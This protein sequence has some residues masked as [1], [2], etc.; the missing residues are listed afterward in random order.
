MGMSIIPS[1]GLSKTQVSG[2]VVAAIIA[3]SVGIAAMG[4]LTYFRKV[5]PLKTWLVPYT[6]TSQY[7]GIFLYS[8]VIWGVLW[9]GLFFALRKRQNMGNLRTWL[10]FFLVC[11]GIGTGFAEA[12]LDWSLLPTVMQLGNTSPEPALTSGPISNEIHV[13]LLQ[14]SSIQGNPA[15]EPSAVTVN[16]DSVITWE[17][18]DTAPHT[19]T[20]G[21]GM[22][23]TE[24]GKLFDSGSIGSGQKFSLSAS[25][26][27]QAGNYQYYCVVHPFMK[28]E[29]IVQ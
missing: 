2:V 5:E 8:N 21:N 1:L 18:I 3:A 11:L 4:V 28:G 19:V 15:Y 17:N 14:G 26:L 7:G 16:K 27:G 24:S 22:D 23:D 12:S 9:V 6:H 10:I 20:S 29:I 25:L 13:S